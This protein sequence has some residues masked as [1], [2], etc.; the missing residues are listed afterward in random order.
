MPKV[1]YDNLPLRAKM[2]LGSCFV[3]AMFA[4]LGLLALRDLGQVNASAQ[5][6]AGD[7][8][9]SVQLPGAMKAA[10]A[11]LRVLQYAQML[12]E[13]SMDRDNLA[14]Q[15]RLQIRVM[16]ALLQQLE[17][18]VDTDAERAAN[19]SLHQ[20]W[21]AY[22]AGHEKVMLL[23]GEFGARAMVGD[24][25][26]LFAELNADLDRWLEL[27]QQA[28]REHVGAARANYASAWLR[29]VVGIAL[30]SVISLL[31]AFRQA[32]R[33]AAPLVG[34]AH[35][36]RAVARG[37]L[38]HHIARAGRDEVG[39][40]LDALAGMQDGLRSLVTAVRGSVDAVSGASGEIADGNRDLSHRTELQAANLQQ[41][42]ASIEQMTATV[43]Q[44]T[45]SSRQANE[46]AAGASGAASR[47]GEVVG[48]VVATMGQITQSAQRIGD[49]IGVI[50]SIAFQTNIL[51]LNAAVEAARAGEQGR[52]FAVVAA[53]VRELAK[54]SAD[55]AKEIKVLIEA[56]TSSAA[57]GTKLVKEAGATMND[58]VTGV[59]EVN[60]LIRDIAAASS[61]QSAAVD[62]INP[63]FGK[64]STYTSAI[65]FAPATKK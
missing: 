19:K 62:E 27:G 64:A 35:S 61:E 15:A 22:L 16:A 36:M 11:N 34:A 2:A 9:P 37:D 26:R 49:I 55:A 20:H 8:L 25:V 23:T 4:L 13:D 44:T 59:R 45:D 31:L 57:H 53:E 42:A 38:T 5:Q 32:D 48:Q 30:C 12:A 63:S 54:R 52:G 3:V 56:S 47:G 40:L 17:P 43:Q 14:A 51:A 1:W 7:T 29:L 18:F 58:V 60:G 50:D 6:L 10:V 28:S 33:I 65:E 41:A 39:Q 24:Y 21:G 46:L